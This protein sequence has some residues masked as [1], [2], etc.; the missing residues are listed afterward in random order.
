MFSALIIKFFTIQIIE[1]E[2]W[3]QKA[4]NLHEIVIKEPFR[5]GSFYSNTSLYRRHPESPQPLVIDVPVFHLYIDP[6]SI[7]ERC[8]DDIAKELWSF[9]SLPLSS[10]EHFDKQFTYSR[11][12]SRKL[13]VEL[14]KES[15]DAIVTWWRGY[16]RANKIAG[17]AIYF[18][19]D[20][21]RS[22]PFGSL[23]GQ[24][25]HTIRDTKEEV[26]KQG[27]PTGGLELYFNEQLTGTLGKRRIIRSLR[28][29]IAKGELLV[30][31]HNG[32]DIYLTIN[33][34]IQSIVEEELAHAITTAKAVGGWAV[35]MEPATGEIMALAQYPFFDPMNYHEYFND[36]D[37]VE[38]SKIRAVTDAYEPGSSMKPIT[39]AIALQANKELQASGK[40]ALFDPDEKL[41]TSRGNFPGRS[42]DLKDGRVHKFLNMYQA[43]QKS[44]N[45]YVARLAQRIVETMGDEWYR[46][47][48]ENF[49]FGKKTYIELPAEAQG[50]VPTPGVK[51][52]SGALQWSKPT[53]FSLAMGHNI[54]MNSIQHARAYCIFANGGFLVTP[55][56]VKKIVEHHDDGSENVILENKSDDVTVFPKILDEDII[57]KV[58]KGMKYV[59][60]MGG[61]ARRADISGY[62]EA[63]KS[64][65]SE[66]IIDGKYS[67][68]RYI[69]NFI[70]F[71][72][73]KNPRF[74]LLVVID[75]PSRVYLPYIG[76]NWHGGTCAS[77]AFRNIAFRTLEYLGVSPDDPHGYPVG[78]PRRDAKEADW[79]DEIEELRETYKQW[80]EQ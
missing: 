54:I 39:V 50:L 20:Y 21:Q 34:Y 59:T 26:T 53:P 41:D 79:L 18:I 33:H 80:N 75:E 2:K 7:P 48:I 10:R 28:N 15:H 22:Y 3:S 49:G 11:S 47:A 46:Q 63:G 65:T 72:P 23:L 6:A 68:E 66:K 29:P 36:K 60:K 27:L 35:M 38:D 43:L 70:G 42:R 55:T 56:I 64:G 40:E 13:I 9:A 44:S 5:R 62:T 17:N 61:T 4:K 31:P 14:D 32:A 19:N 78:D 74:V 67:D 1:G 45:I 69:S 30:A 73:L 16:S 71:A 58:I 51:Y 24:A 57:E 52:A 37:L 12:R 25:L 76:K 8:H 77:P